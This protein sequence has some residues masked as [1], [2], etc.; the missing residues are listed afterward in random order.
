MKCSRREMISCS[1]GATNLKE[2][3]NLKESVMST[4]CKIPTFQ[5]DRLFKFESKLEFS[6]KLSKTKKLSK[7]ETFSNLKRTDLNLTYLTK[8]TNLEKRKRNLQG[9]LPSIRNSKTRSENHPNSIE[10]QKTRVSA[11]PPSTH[12]FCSLKISLMLLIHNDIHNLSIS[13]MIISSKKN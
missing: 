1:N 9:C 2:T 4:F 12:K 8:S 5:E 11:E 10:E 6:L 3:L 7:S 13:I